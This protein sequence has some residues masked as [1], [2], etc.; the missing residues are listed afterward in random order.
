MKYI[1]RNIDAN[2][3]QPVLWF[4][5]GLLMV[6]YVWLWTHLLKE[7]TVT[8]LPSG[9]IELFVIIKFYWKLFNIGSEWVCETKVN[10]VFFPINIQNISRVIIKTTKIFLSFDNLIYK[11]Y[12][13]I[14]KSLNF[15]FYDYFGKLP[16]WIMKSNNLIY[17]NIILF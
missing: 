5:S 12:D 8:V 15:T 13:K 17:I 7:L 10:F 11:I 4:R 9:V 1:L 2:Q 14:H 3:G 16:L 6:Y